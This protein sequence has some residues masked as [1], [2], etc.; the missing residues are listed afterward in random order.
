MSLPP[1]LAPLAANTLLNAENPPMYIDVRMPS[2]YAAGH[3]PNAL[4]VPVTLGGGV[5]VPTF[6]QDI[7]GAVAGASDTSTL[8]IGCKSGKRSTM[9]INILKNEGFEQL[10]ELEGGFDAWISHSDLSVE[11]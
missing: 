11:L 2:E 10:V 1:S 8:M 9:A 3:V 6:V 4:N 7:Q 5:V